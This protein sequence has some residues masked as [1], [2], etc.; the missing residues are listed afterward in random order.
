MLPY[1]N[2][3]LLG[4]SLTSGYT[5]GSD[6]PYGVRLR[7]IL[8]QSFPDQSLLVDIEGVPGDGVVPAGVFSTFR[9]RLNKRLRY[10]S[11][12]G[13]D[14]HVVVVLGGTNDLLQFTAPRIFSS[15]RDLHS[16]CTSPDDSTQVL[17]C[18]LPRVGMFIDTVNE[19][20]KAAETTRREVNEMI[21]TISHPRVHPFDLSSVLDHASS[22][23]HSAVA[24]WDEDGV[25]CTDQGYDVMGELIGNEV[26]RLPRS[27]PDHDAADP[28]TPPPPGPLLVAH[29]KSRI[30]ADLGIPPAEQ[31]FQTP[32]GTPLDD[33]ESLFPHSLSPNDPP[34]FLHLLL[35]L[36]GGKGGF[37][38]NLRS[39]GGRMSS[40]KTNNTE[41]CRDLQGRRL[42]T[43]NDA[44]KL[45]EYTEKEQERQKQR[46]ADRERKIAEG[47]R[48]PEKRKVLFNDPQYAADHE[49]ALDEVKEAMQQAMSL[50]RK[51]AK[52]KET[53]VVKK[54]KLGPSGSGIAKAGH[55]AAAPK[56]VKGW[57]DEDE[58][59][60][61]SDKEGDGEPVTAS[62]GEE[63]AGEE[64]GEGESE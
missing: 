41:A 12:E 51:K 54:A 36:R 23:T 17:A 9:G 46:A 27:I 3:L 31:R 14:Y 64:E 56:V 8:S 48:E 59:D 6:H 52:G 21:R 39:Q 4:D 28:P 29:L 33:T 15:L 58:S 61:G 62:S 35:R 50:K 10:A 53:E 13:W 1:L 30:H 16:I 5:S 43:L 18:T 60:D 22:S 45:A 32:G 20:F 19:R 49:K 38:A 2:I 26:V 44:K 40:Q 42:K 7:A 25:H 55:A 37:G 63:K 34:T 57:D 47:L 24:L 11:E